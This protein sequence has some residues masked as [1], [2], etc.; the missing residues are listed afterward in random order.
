MIVTSFRPRLPVTR[1]YGYPRQVPERYFTSV[2]GFSGCAH[3]WAVPTAKINTSTKVIG[4]IGGPPVAVV[5]QRE[6]PGNFRGATS[7]VPIL[8]TRPFGWRAKCQGRDE[9]TGR[10]R[11]LSPSIYPT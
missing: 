9:R 5:A 10:G 2:T 3:T 11:T 1:S 6:F 8:S 7:Y 4:F